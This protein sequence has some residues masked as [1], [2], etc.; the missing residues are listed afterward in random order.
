M[1]EVGERERDGKTARET[2]DG[3]ANGGLAMALEFF[4]RDELEME[5]ESHEHESDSGKVGAGGLAHLHCA[6][7]LDLSD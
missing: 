6:K 4:L 2:L 1:G 5:G 7:G 3:A